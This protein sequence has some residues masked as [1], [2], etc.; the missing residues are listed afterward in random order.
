M[1]DVAAGAPS[2]ERGELV[3]E[4]G[5]RLHRTSW[6]APDSRASVL[7]SHG[8]G[9]HCGRY[10]T[11]GADLVRHGISLHAMD[12][13]GHGHS[14]GRRGHVLGFG[15]FL[16]DFDRFRHAVAAESPP[17]RPLFLLGH[18]LGGL[19]ALRYLQE[20]PH[21]GLR[22]AVLS[23]P[24]LGVALTPPRWK[25]ALAR[26]LARVLPSLPMS[27]SIDAADLTHDE[28]HA[29]A[30]RTDAL[31]H[32]TVT[33]RLYT[34]MLMAIESAFA[35]P[36][37]L[38]L[39]LLFLVPG[40]DRIVRS[41]ETLRFAEGLAGDVTVRTYPGFRHELFNE[42]HR[43]LAVRDTTDWLNARIA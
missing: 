43:A 1:S 4:D 19:I 2:G 35:A 31:V 21:A 32:R 8:L 25:T 15:T 30:Y 37:R 34:S 27:G 18:S 6:R 41:E 3:A 33:P 24:L 7:L 29:E 38:H 39:P 23:A 11:L 12:H 20:H 28:A 40:E 26:A 22:G 14:G 42:V 36:E 13:R 10:E 17:G 16:G 5:V 9:E